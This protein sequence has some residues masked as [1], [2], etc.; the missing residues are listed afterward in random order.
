MSPLGIPK[1]PLPLPM[2]P[3]ETFDDSFLRP[4]TKKNIINDPENV[5]YRYDMD[6]SVDYETRD[7]IFTPKVSKIP[8]GSLGD[9]I[10]IPPTE[11]LPSSLLGATEPIVPSTEVS[12]ADVPLFDMIQFDYSKYARGVGKYA[13]TVADALKRAFR[14]V[15][16]NSSLS[17]VVQDNAKIITLLIAVGTGALIMKFGISALLVGLLAMFAAKTVL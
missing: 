6:L 13:S 15:T 16:K 14:M 1:Y 9:P 4:I 2:A 11:D 17:G 10:P 7:D 8:P 3:R 12:R 5:D